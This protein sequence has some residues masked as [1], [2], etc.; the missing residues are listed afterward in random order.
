MSAKGYTKETNTLD[1]EPVRGSI[2][3]GRS[4]QG[5]GRKC[6][7]GNMRFIKVCSEL[8]NV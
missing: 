7:A 5:R 8:L 6:G 1:K 2:F 3:A 4:F